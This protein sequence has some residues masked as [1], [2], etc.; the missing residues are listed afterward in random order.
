MGYAQDSPETD[1]TVQSA[2]N[3]LFGKNGLFLRGAALGE[4]ASRDA[5]DLDSLFQVNHMGLTFE[6]CIT[7]RT[8]NSEIIIYAATEE[9][10]ETEFR[11]SKQ[12]TSMQLE[13]EGLVTVQQ[14]QAIYLSNGQSAG[15]G[16]PLE[17]NS[18]MIQTSCI[19]PCPGISPFLKNLL[20]YLYY[21]SVHGCDNH[22]RKVDKGLCIRLLEVLHAY[23]CIGQYKTDSPFHTT[24]VEMLIYGV[25]QL[26]LI[27][28]KA[29][30][31]GV[32]APFSYEFVPVDK[33]QNPDANSCLNKAQ[34]TQIIERSKNISKDVWQQLFGLSAIPTP[35][36]ITTTLRRVV[37]AASGLTCSSEIVHLLSLLCV[38]SIPVPQT[39][40]LASNG[41]VMLTTFLKNIE[42]LQCNTLSQ[43][44]Q[45]F[46][47]DK[48]LASRDM[49][50][51]KKQL[52]QFSDNVATISTKCFTP[53]TCQ[54]NPMDD[55]VNNGFGEMMLLAGTLGRFCAFDPSY[56][57]ISGSTSIKCCRDGKFFITV[58]IQVK[59]GQIIQAYV[60]LWPSEATTAERKLKTCTRFA[61]IDLGD[62][63][64]KLKIAEALM[65]NAGAERRE[66]LKEI[67]KNYQ[68]SVT[69][70]FY[71]NTNQ[72]KLSF[73]TNFIL[74]NA[75]DVICPDTHE[76]G[77]GVFEYSGFIVYP[78]WNRE[79]P[80][81]PYDVYN[82]P[83][84]GPVLFDLHAANL[85]FFNP[86]ATHKDHHKMGTRALRQLL[87]DPAVRKC[88]REQASFY[89]VSI[90]YIDQLLLGADP[91][92]KADK[93][94]PCVSKRSTE[95]ANSC[96][97]CDRVPTRNE[98]KSPL[99][100]G[101]KA[102]Q[103]VQILHHVAP[104][105]FQ[106][107]LVIL[108]NK[109]LRFVASLV[110]IN[111]YS[112]EEQTLLLFCCL[113]HK[114]QP[115]K[116]DFL[117][118]VNRGFLKIDSSGNRRLSDEEYNR[119]KAPSK[120]TTEQSVNTQFADW[121]VNLQ[122]EYQAE[123]NQYELVYLHGQD[124]NDTTTCLSAITTG[125]QTRSLK[126]R[127]AEG[128]PETNLQGPPS[129]T[130][131]QAAPFTLDNLD[132]VFD[133]LGSD[134]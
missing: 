4:R 27:Y 130:D 47:T 55:T 22:G 7:K 95:I 97:P 72:S 114:Q 12:V 133:L 5:G 121:G 62:V 49:D 83:V 118:D 84:R 36:T 59:E 18:R 60:D 61:R 38:Y 74:K 108:F 65:K 35:H 98:H 131:P 80:L 106:R 87:H 23:F 76:N 107:F 125:L 117:S 128:P 10:R 48:W 90:Q 46:V 2:Y 57:H 77:E 1:S 11:D 100:R 58:V 42:D 37:T 127:K 40:V 31:F 54:P 75:I 85:L 94:D 102:R 66:A 99:S 110:T 93:S 126:K 8:D 64:L 17:P 34:I 16:S 9:C 33:I 132:L 115:D 28:S 89:G 21:I 129:E 96:N 119:C 120:Y 56:I 50:E 73:T 68:K 113:L 103:L 3:T 86:Q 109:M 134:F 52:K 71:D 104:V 116:Y 19:Y 105:Y 91:K 43:R 13:W 111:E 67:R 39:H 101:E 92:D 88:I 45:K 29:T 53:S 51:L 112:T 26:H 79:I 63:F 44:K 6:P 30:N 122:L 25:A 24:G 14:N 123:S 20:L 81:M 32:Q 15:L 70:Y 124:G 82:F 78:N 69:S 41:P